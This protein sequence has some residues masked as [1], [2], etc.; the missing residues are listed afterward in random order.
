[1]PIKPFTDRDFRKSSFSGTND[2]SN[3]G[4]N[5]VMVA[6]GDEVAVRHSKDA[7]KTTLTFSR[8]EW[9]AFLAGAKA[10]EFDLV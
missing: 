4:S 2:G 5:C 9:A 6:R 10:G 1:M 3:D 8:G 7:G